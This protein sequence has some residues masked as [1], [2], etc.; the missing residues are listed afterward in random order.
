MAKFTV[1]I[2]VLFLAGWTVE[3]QAGFKKPNQDKDK[4]HG[5]DKDSGSGKKGGKDATKKDEAGSGDK[6]KRQL[7]E[8]IQNIAEQESKP[9][10]A[11]YS[12]G[13]GH[14]DSGCGWSEG[15]DGWD[16]SGH[17][18]TQWGGSSSSGWHSSDHTEGRHHGSRHRPRQPSRSSNWDPVALSRA[19]SS[20]LRYGGRDGDFP[21]DHEGWA[22]VNNVIIELH[23][24]FDQIQAVVSG[25]YEGS[26]G[27]IRLE[28]SSDGNR[29]R[30]IRSRG[31]RGGG[32]THDG[33]S[34]G[35][36]TPLF[37]PP[38]KPAPGPE[39]TPAPP[40]ISHGDLEEFWLR[41]RAHFDAK[42]AG[43]EARIM[44]ALRASQKQ[45]I[46][47]FESMYEEAEK[48]AKEEEEQLQRAKNEASGT[49]VAGEGTGTTDTTTIFQAGEPTPPVATP[50]E[51]PAPGSGSGTST[52]PAASTSTTTVAPEDKT[53]V[54]DKDAGSKD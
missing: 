20:L 10:R 47:A 21:V 49:G 54:E 27:R 44:Q 51:G 31:R 16:G 8:A 3:V 32:L 28:L 30:S 33:G 13:D 6:W 26:D 46:D 35:P 45:V 38:S 50:A 29:I 42:V 43:S 39:N 15:G 7:L 53:S 25:V 23:T 24:T 48:A 41:I 9:K 34:S 14:D 5:K 1:W 17:S 36:F 37:G 19:L 18:A 52:P 4:G 22:D 12:S 40:A 11:R 2:L